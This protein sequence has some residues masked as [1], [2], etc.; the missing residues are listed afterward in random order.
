MLAEQGSHRMDGCERLDEDKG[1]HGS[2]RLSREAGQV[3][4]L[5]GK[6]SI[7]DLIKE[8]LNEQHVTGRWEGSDKVPVKRMIQQSPSPPSSRIYITSINTPTSSTIWPKSDEQH[9]A[10]EAGGRKVGRA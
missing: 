5:G 9:A 4:A 7:K 1:R 10:G 8:P 6:D 2:D 3:S